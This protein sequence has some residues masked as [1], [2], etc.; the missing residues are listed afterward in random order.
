VPLV[1]LILLGIS[2]E[3]EVLYEDS[4]YDLDINLYDELSK[5]KKIKN[6]E[7]PQDYI[8]LHRGTTSITGKQVLDYLLNRNISYDKIER[9]RLGFCVSG[10]YSGRIIIPVYDYKNE[11]IFFVARSYFANVDKKILNPSKELTGTGKSEILFNINNNI[12]K[13]EVIVNEGPFDAMSTDGVALFGKIASDEQIHKIKK[14]KANSIIIMLD[15]D[16]TKYAYELADKL[17]GYKKVY[18]CELVEGDPNTNIDKL[19]EILKNKKEYNKI[20]G[21]LNKLRIC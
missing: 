10:Y 7:L 13:D 1:E 4:D 17:Y 6:I 18:I 12:N 3:D 8:P 2:V 20:S 11:L 21:L 19:G 5:I 16:A 14:L 15:S 9:Y